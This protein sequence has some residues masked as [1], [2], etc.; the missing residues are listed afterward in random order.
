[1]NQGSITIDIIDSNPV[2]SIHYSDLETFKDLMFFMLS[3]SG[4]E[5]FVTTIQNQLYAENKTE[6]LTIL[7]FLLNYYEKDQSEQ[8]EKE[9]YYMRPSS[10]K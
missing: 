4:Y 8:I 1:M 10:F 6:E 2:I 7:N 5:L 3:E 9:D